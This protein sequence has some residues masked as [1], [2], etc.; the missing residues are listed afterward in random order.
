MTFVLESA[1]HEALESLA[2]D[3]HRN[4]ELHHEPLTLGGDAIEKEQLER[5]LCEFETLQTRIEEL[6]SV[7]LGEF[8]V[9]YGDDAAT[10]IRLAEVVGELITMGKPLLGLPAGSTMAP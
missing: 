6:E 5:A 7:V 10:F 3:I 9:A 8:E 2:A 4:V 1:Q